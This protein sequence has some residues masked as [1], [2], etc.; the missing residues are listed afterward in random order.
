MTGVRVADAV[1][2]Y[3]E[4]KAVGD[5]DGP[6][7][8]AYASNAASILRRFITWLEREHDVVSVFELEAE[9]MRA[10]ASELETRTD[11]G[12][13]AASTAGTYYAVVRAFL[14]WCVQGG[15]LEENPAETEAARA[16]LPSEDTENGSRAWSSE[17]RRELETYVERRALEA[18]DADRRERLS[19]L[20]EYALVATLAHASVRG[21]ELFRV[22]ED[23]RRD[24]ATWGDVDFYR[25]RIRVLGKSGRLEDVPLPAAART[26][27]RR[28]RIVLDPPSTEW[29]LF[30]TRH[31][32]SIARRVRSTLRERG[33]DDEEIETLLE[34]ETAVT[35][36]RTRTIAP[37]AITTEGA[38]SI[39]KRLCSEAGVDVDGNYLT[40][41]GAR[42]GLDGD[43]RTAATTAETALR[44]DVPER[45]LAVASTGQTTA[46]PGPES[47]GDG[48]EGHTG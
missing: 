12:E 10:Y 17:H 6:G 36:A 25:G 43:T 23:D 35:L 22:P 47:D 33:H 26:P 46:G 38:R 15:I 28:Y 32:P 14:S 4:R 20:R 30:P 16:A 34:E 1:D 5:P 9:H 39:L 41:R 44:T 7:A 37:P 40:P 48:G 21:A 13:Y 45:S 8:G 18:T 42:R 31:A 27:L 24:G 29:P 19:R 2:T 11:R 3:L